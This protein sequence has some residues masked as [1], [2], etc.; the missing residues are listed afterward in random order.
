MWVSGN[1]KKS[2]GIEGGVER[3][4][5]CV[6]SAGVGVGCEESVLVIT[7]PGCG[8]ALPYIYIYL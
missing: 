7:H 4:R 5:R 6:G 1:Q 2:T 8:L 3:E